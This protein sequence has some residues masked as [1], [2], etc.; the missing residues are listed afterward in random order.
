MRIDRFH[1]ERTQCL[2][3]NAVRYNLSESGVQPLRVEELLG[4]G[5]RSRAALL[6]PG[7]Q[8]PRVRRLRAA[9]RAHRAALSGRDG[10]E[11]PRHQRHLRGQLHDALG[12]ARGGRPRRGDAPDL[13]ADLGPLA[14]LR[15]PRRRLSAAAARGPAARA[16]WALDV[17]SLERA[18]TKKTRL[19]VVTNPNN[20]TGAV[21]TEEEMDAIVRAARLRQAPGSSPT[22][23]TAAPRCGRRPMSPTFWGRY[24]RVLVTVGALE[25]VRPARAAHRLDRRAAEDRRRGSAGTTTTRRSRRRCCRTGSRGPRSSRAAASRSWRGRARILRENL[26][27]I[28][29]W[30]RSPRRRLRLRPARSPG[31]SPS[32]GYRLPIGSVALFDRL[33]LE[34]SVLITP[35]AHFGIGQVLPGRLRLRHREDARGARAGLR[36]HREA[37]PIASTTQDR[38]K[39]TGRRVLIGLVP[40]A[41][42]SDS[43]AMASC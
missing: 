23:S 17:A 42:Q 22:R 12:P 37:S 16:A 4:R 31:R 2:Y 34:E 3:E 24:P 10:G 5:L 1:M 36:L 20:P 38:R 33:R 39:K 25:G 19:I 14:G 43:E 28:E 32:S 41:V 35:G 6:R 15:R 7:P 8:V 29:A 18:V 11:R 30:I 9:P 13:H 40:P 21:L 27:R 26:P